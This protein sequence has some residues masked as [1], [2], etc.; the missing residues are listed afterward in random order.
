MGKALSGELSC[1]CDSSCY[2]K[3]FSSLYFGVPSPWGPTL[4]PLYTGG[5]YHCYML[6]ESICHF[7]GV[8]A[9]FGFYFILM[10]NPFRKQ[11]RPRSEATLCGI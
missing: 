8:R 10:E 7:R 9:I 3:Q 1:P 11:G 4:N 6:D 2:G 5:L